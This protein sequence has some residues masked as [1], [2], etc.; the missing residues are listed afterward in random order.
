MSPS[1]IPKVL[2]RQERNG[3]Y[4]MPGTIVQLN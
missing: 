2:A 4:K 1:D 3:D